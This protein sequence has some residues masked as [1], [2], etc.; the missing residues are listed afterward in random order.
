[1]KVLLIENQPADADL[2]RWALLKGPYPCDVEWVEKLGLGLER[3]EQGGIDV[4]L[5]D[6][7][8]PDSQGLDSVRR[9]QAQ[10]PQVPIVVLTGSYEDE[11]MAV[12]ALQEGAQDY[13]MKD[14]LDGKVLS[15]AI[16][17]AIERMRAEMELRRSQTE[18]QTANLKLEELLAVKESFIA[19]VSHELRTP[20]AVIKEG[21]GLL[22]D[23]MTGPLGEQQIKFLRLVDRNCLRLA[24]FVSDILDLSKIRAGRMWLLRGKIKLRELIEE[25]L[26]ESQPLMGK[27]VLRLEGAQARAVLGD[28]GKIRQ[29]LT[30]LLSNAV[31]FT[32]DDGAITLSIREEGEFVTTIVQDDGVGIAKEDIPKLFQEFSQVGEYQERGT[33]LGLALCKSIIERHKGTISVTSEPGKGATF[34]FTLPLYTPKVAL[35]EAFKDLVEESAKH[36][37]SSTVALIAVDCENLSRMEALEELEKLLRPQL[38]NGDVVLGFDLKW[39][40]VLTVADTRA[41]RAMSGRIRRVLEE[42]AV[43]RLGARAGEAVPIAMGS[44]FYPVD[45]TDDAHKLFSIAQDFA[46]PVTPEKIEKKQILLAEDDPSVLEVTKLR[47]EQLGYD[48]LTATN[49]EEVLSHF[50]GHDAPDLLLI[51]LKMP[52]LDGLGVVAKL[53]AVPQAEKTPIVAFTAYGEELK[54]KCLEIGILHI[55]KKPLG[56]GELLDKVRQALGEKEP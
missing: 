17:Y 37:G 51:D 21:V 9:V 41:V 4:V 7:G 55:V 29:V 52:K 34:T 13:L 8:L 15:R 39:L 36:L 11:S 12:E 23:G 44:A 48:V 47:L 22:L 5:L 43:T 3:L 30:N 27:R 40:I 56:A 26:K 28:T 35:E 49:G 25:V 2:A 14:G 18:L 1:M 24:E 20:V 33:G 50:E 54:D 42:W 19:N 53:K 45:G 38:K 6:L 32:K 46:K 16:R 31:K 10:A